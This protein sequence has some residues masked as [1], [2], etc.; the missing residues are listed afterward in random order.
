MNSQTA[1]NCI[2]S[3]VVIILILAVTYFALKK[4]DK[5]AEQTPTKNILPISI[6]SLPK[7]KLIC[8][9]MHL[10]IQPSTKFD[11]YVDEPIYE[12]IEV[13]TKFRQNAC[14]FKIMDEQSR[15]SFNSNCTFGSIRFDESIVR[16]SFSFA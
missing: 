6:L 4:W 10:N 12:N 9:Q 7:C 1:Q 2:I 8:P 11:N 15:E 16:A 14:T 13:I 5:R 3:L